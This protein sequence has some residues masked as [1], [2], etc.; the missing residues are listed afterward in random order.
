MSFGL[1]TASPRPM[2]KTMVLSRGTCIGFVYPNRFISAGTT[3]FLYF[4]R[5]RGSTAFA[6]G[7]ALLDR[8]LGAALG[9]A[10]LLAVLD[11]V[12]DAARLIAGRVDQHHLAQ[13]DRRL[14]LEDAA[15]ALRRLLDVA[16]HAVHPF[17]HD[18]AA[19]EQ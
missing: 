7:S 1:A 4:S 5:R 16:L 19:I 13:R 14:D 12:L 15:R 11:L 9:D 17:D 8:E 10:D 18:Q 3:S 2:F 6:M